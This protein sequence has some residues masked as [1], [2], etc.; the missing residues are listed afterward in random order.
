[1]KAWYAVLAKPRQEHI[2]AD[3]L[4]RQAFEVFLPL[5]RERKRLRG[6]YDWV[7]QAL[8]P[9][10]LFIHLD[11]GTDNAAP[12]RSS[13]GCCGLV[14]F[15]LK[16][17]ALPEGVVENLRSRCDAFGRLRLDVPAAAVWQ[18]GQPL[19]VTE[20]P[21]AGLEA[22]FK[23]RNGAERVTILLNWLGGPR[24]VQVSELSIACA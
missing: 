8:F 11:L 5:A 15:G 4:Q 24:L 2:A 6:R 18:P 16:T 3:H 22:V 1:M 23:A 17:P 9:R 14:R 19:R 10:Y 20:G 7:V 13:I 12:V 21:F